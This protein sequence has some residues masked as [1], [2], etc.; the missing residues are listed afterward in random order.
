MR[1]VFS[2][3]PLLTYIRVVVDLWTC[4]R[5][6]SRK[7][8]FKAVSLQGPIA[9]FSFSGALANLIRGNYLTFAR[10]PMDALA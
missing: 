9:L 10:S 3:C 1:R 5:G 6:S 7:S 8:P 4:G 2:R